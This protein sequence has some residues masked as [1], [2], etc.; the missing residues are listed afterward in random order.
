[1]TTPCRICGYHPGAAICSAL[2]PKPE[3]VTDSDLDLQMLRAKNTQLHAKIADLSDENKRL[4][5]LAYSLEA[6]LKDVEK[7]RDSLRSMIDWQKEREQ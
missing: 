6:T 4:T 7:D 3:V 2:H 1:M 5:L